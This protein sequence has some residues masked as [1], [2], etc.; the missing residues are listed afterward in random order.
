MIA[1]PSPASESEASVAQGF[2]HTYAYHA[3]V[4][5]VAAVAAAVVAAAD[6]HSLEM[7]AAE[8]LTT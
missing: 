1:M 3:A 2:A 7:R 8:K 6:S 4:A 5:A